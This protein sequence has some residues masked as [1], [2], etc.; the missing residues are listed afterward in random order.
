MSCL[1]VHYRA[2]WIAASGVWVLVLRQGSRVDMVVF[3]QAFPSLSI[4]AESPEVGFRYLRFQDH[5]VAIEK[6]KV[7][8]A[9]RVDS[10]LSVHEGVHTCCGGG[11]RASSRAVVFGR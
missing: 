10:T 5:M 11:G 3:S 4:P 9:A 2:C 1:Y 8:A 6:I 7:E